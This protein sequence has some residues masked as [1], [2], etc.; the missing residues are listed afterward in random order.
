MK[1]RVA[2]EYLLKVVMFHEPFLCSVNW[3][4]GQSMAHRIIVSIC[5]NNK[6]K[7]M[8]DS[9]HSDN[10]VLFKNCFYSSFYSYRR[11]FDFFYGS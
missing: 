6:R 4:T 5:F 11:Y 7:I 8:T 10:V 3:S 9:V 1:E 2:A